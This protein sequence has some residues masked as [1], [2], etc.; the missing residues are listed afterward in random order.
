MHKLAVSSW[1]PYQHQATAL[2]QLF[3]EP[4]FTRI[5]LAQVSDSQHDAAMGPFLV[6]IE[7]GV[8]PV[9][10]LQAIVEALHRRY[11]ERQLLPADIVERAQVRALADMIEERF[12]RHCF[13]AIAAHDGFGREIWNAT[14]AA[15][16]VIISI[17]PPLSSIEV[18]QQEVNSP[19]LVG[20]HPTLADCLLA[21]TWWT[22]EDQGL[23]NLLAEQPSLSS[24]YQRNCH[25]AP[26]QRVD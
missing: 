26:F 22:T 10:G 7:D 6:L 12:S 18:Q 15:P 24:W 17:P 2:E 19:Y 20:E 21:A 25:G 1:Y 16:E 8:A 9:I 4:G 23:H 5:D 14:S 13:A 3:G 11:P